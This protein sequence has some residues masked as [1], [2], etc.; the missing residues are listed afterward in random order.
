MKQSYIKNPEETAYGFR[1]KLEFFIKRIENLKLKLNKEKKN[2][3]ILDVGCGNGVFLTF[4]LGEHGYSVTGI[5][6]HKP[7]IEF[8][9]LKN[10]SANINFLVSR[11]EELVSRETHHKFDVIIFSD[12]LEHIEDP[13]VLLRS[14]RSLLNENGI[15]LISIPNGY[16][17]FEIENFILRK[18]GIL[19][20]ARCIFKTQKAESHSNTQT[21]NVESGHIQFFTMRHFKKI[22]AKSGLQISKFKKGSFM[23][24]SVS[25]RVIS[26]FSFFTSWN[27]A[28]SKY[29]PYF[30]CS[31]WYFECTQ[32]N[33]CL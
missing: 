14:A 13:I 19:W 22:L 10:N 16:G 30:M 6:I 8:A 1:A 17:P 27:R 20:L 15:I 26:A 7:S 4:P 21:L 25:S 28:I 31:V 29:L 3:H 24:G 23:C 12:I 33:E 11:I 5:D 18:M 9:N 32:K 2:M